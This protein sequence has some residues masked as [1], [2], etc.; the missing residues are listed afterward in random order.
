MNHSLNPRPSVAVRCSVSMLTLVMTVGSSPKISFAA[1]KA[2][3]T[4]FAIAVVLRG[5][6]WDTTRSQSLKRMGVESADRLTPFLKDPKLRSAALV[7][8]E[9]W[10]DKKP[11]EKETIAELLRLAEDKDFEER[12]LAYSLYLTSIPET[13][14]ISFVK[15]LI[16]TLGPL[17]I[18]IASA[19]LNRL[20]NS[21]SGRLQLEQSDTTKMIGQVVDATERLTREKK[22][23]DLVFWIAREPFASDSRHR[24][25]VA[26]V[27]LKILGQLTDG[28]PKL[29][30]ATGDLMYFLLH[31]SKADSKVIKEGLV[32]FYVRQNDAIVAAAA[33]ATLNV[34]KQHDDAE[35]QIWRD[36]ITEVCRRKPTLEKLFPKASN[37]K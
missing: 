3:V 27:I 11:L 16:A 23:L 35:N 37:T 33:T 10:P 30:E 2:K 24:D 36:V 17:E 31:N 5:G 14:Q 25:H 21:E 29:D 12:L 8:I 9:Y 4:D 20:A 28:K 18:K 26:R 6:P 7:A 22:N 19:H 13:E 15:R 1:E 34:L 32:D